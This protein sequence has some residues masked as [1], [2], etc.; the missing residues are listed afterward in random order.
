MCFCFFL[1]QGAP[2][3]LNVNQRAGRPN[4]TRKQKLSKKTTTKIAW[5][6][7]THMGQSYFN[8]P[9]LFLQIRVGEENCKDKEGQ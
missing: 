5:D 4:D 9:V 3:I 8:L 7:V 2:N 6:N 1:P